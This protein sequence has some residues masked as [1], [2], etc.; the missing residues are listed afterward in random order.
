[1]K[2]FAVIET[3]DV[4]Q[5]DVG[6]RR[7]GS[8]EVAGEAVGAHDQAL[9]GGANFRNRSVESVEHIDAGSARAL[10]LRR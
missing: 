1:M 3:M 2:L 10:S 5:F 4:D 8:F 9:D 7:G 6:A